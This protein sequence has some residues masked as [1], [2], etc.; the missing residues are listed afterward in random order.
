MIDIAAL[1]AQNKARLN[2]SLD[3]KAITF[4]KDSL[5][6]ADSC[7][8][9]IELAVKRATQEKEDKNGKVRKVMDKGLR[10]NIAPETIV[11]TTKGAKGATKSRTN[12]E[13]MRSMMETRNAMNIRAINDVDDAYIQYFTSVVEVLDTYAM[14]VCTDMYEADPTIID[15]ANA[16]VAAIEAEEEAK[17][18]AKKE[19]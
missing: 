7:W 19:K 5:L 10:F 9:I 18:T 14:T 13:T 4:T 6:D 1:R 12:I 2:G 16:A 3:G 11:G 17:K 15:K 8:K